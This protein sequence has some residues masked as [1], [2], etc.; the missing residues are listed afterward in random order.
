MRQLREFLAFELWHAD[1]YTLT[2]HD[3][4]FAVLIVVLTRALVLGLN[5]F[6]LKPFFRRNAVD[7]GR[8]YA[9]SQMLTY[10]LY[11]VGIYSAFSVIGIQ[12]SVI[13]AG[14]AALLVGVGLG[15][16]Q[17]FNDFFSGL[18]LL[19]EGPVEVGNVV[20]VDGFIG[21]VVE[22]GLRTS[23]VV[24]RDDIVIIVPNSHLVVDNIVNWSHNRQPLRFNIEVG[25]AYGS[26]VDLVTKLLEKA[27][28]EHPD[29]LERPVPRVMFC[30][31]GSSALDF[32]LYFYSREPWRIEFV[33]SDLR[34]AVNKL[35][36]ARGVQIPFP[37]RDLWLRNPETL[38][39]ARAQESPALPAANGHSPAEAPDAEPVPVAA[40]APADAKA[41]GGRPVR[42]R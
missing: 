41:P 35:F 40:P 13:W 22:I 23:K 2:V 24:T 12:F 18:L 11:V 17:T 8:S 5:R 27:A 10:V 4:V 9:V 33:K 14:A 38:R 25:V 42:A 31:F 1:S 29:V 26:D 34:Y 21:R 32:K 3:F 16:Q 37:Q 36:A 28:D 30:D 19:V 6:I 7:L 39:A 20:E 15:L